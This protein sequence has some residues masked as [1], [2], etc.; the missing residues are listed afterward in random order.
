MSLDHT[1]VI[2]G[3][4]EGKTL[5]VLA[6]SYTHKASGKETGSAYALIEVTVVGNGPP[7]HIHNTEEKAFYVLAGS[8]NVLV[9]EQ[10]VEANAGTFVLVPRGTVH[11]FSKAGTESAKILLILSPAGFE[12]F[13]DEISGPPDLEKIN[14]LAPKYNL[15]IVGTP[16]GES[17]SDHK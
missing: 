11:A 13:F 3:P 4:G 7:P 14:A 5:S 15:E 8:L 10:T 12:N 2:L 17:G 9:G 16:V 1:A 6:D